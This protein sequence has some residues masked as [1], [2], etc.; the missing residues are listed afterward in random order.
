LKPRKVRKPA[1]QEQQGNREP[2]EVEDAWKPRKVK[3]PGSSGRY[4]N[5]V[6]LEDCLRQFQ[7]SGG[8]PK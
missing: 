4:S 7:G 2:K 8:K 6:H 5:H 3:K 1:S